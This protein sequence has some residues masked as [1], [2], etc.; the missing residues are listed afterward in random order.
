[1]QLEFRLGLGSIECLLY[2]GAHLEIVDQKWT[3]QEREIKII[4]VL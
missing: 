2:L 3:E 4:A 1:M